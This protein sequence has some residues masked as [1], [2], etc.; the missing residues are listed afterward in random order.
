MGPCVTAYY[1][2]HDPFAAAWLREL[3]ADGLIAPGVVDERSIEDVLPDDVR[4][5]TQCHFFAGIGVWSL[6]LRAAHWHDDRPI[7]TGSAPCQP[8]SAAGKGDGFVDERHLWPAFHWLIV[9]GKERNIPVVGEQV[10][11]RDGL[12]WLDLV[13][14]DMEGSNY[15]FGAVDTCAAGFGAPFIGQRLYWLAASACGEEGPREIRRSSDTTPNDYRKTNQL[16]NVSG[17]RGLAASE[18]VDSGTGLR[19]YRPSNNAQFGRAV[20]SDNGGVGGLAE[21]NMQPGRLLRRQPIETIG[22]SATHDRIPFCSLNYWRNAE[23]LLC[24]DPN[25]ARFRPVEPGT[26][27]LV[28]ARTL[29]NRMDEVRGAGNAVNIAQAQG[30]IEAVMEIL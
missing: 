3:I 20:A 4:E 5:F 23:W 29:R 27:P 2:E 11:S 28:D 7:W 8:F 1:N 14:A 24:R 21:T 19:D 6:A 13:Q 30:F 10:A 26:F 18:S 25:G 16:G 22:R 17:L 9:N 15:A 12:K